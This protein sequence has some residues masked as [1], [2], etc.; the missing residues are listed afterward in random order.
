MDRY[1]ICCDTKLESN[2]KAITG[3]DE[4]DLP[5]GNGLVF[6]SFVDDNNYIESYICNDCVARKQDKSYLVT[7][8][9]TESPSKNVEPLAEWVKKNINGTIERTK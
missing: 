7:R 5:I 4:F 8:L 2:I 3:V 6:V 1:C 9:P